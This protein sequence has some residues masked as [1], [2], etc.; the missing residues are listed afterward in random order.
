MHYRTATFEDWPKMKELHLAVSRQKNGIARWEDE[1]TDEYVQSFMKKALDYGI[2]I[3]AEHPDDPE[4]FIGEIHA[5]VPN[6]RVFK[7][8]MTDLTIAVHPEFQGKKIGRTLFM[9]FLEEIA[10]NRPDIG[11]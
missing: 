3:V 7:H 8:L 9:I 4:R 5:S 11:K 10:T 2:I 1:V 6:I